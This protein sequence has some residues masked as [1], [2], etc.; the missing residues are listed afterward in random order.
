[1]YGKYFST[2]FALTPKNANKF[3]KALLYPQKSNL[4]RKAHEWE[5]QGKHT[6]HTNA[7]HD[8]KYMWPGLTTD[9]IFILFS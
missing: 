7:F 2:D 8:G 4:Q 9:R 1:M 5:V 6:K 3:L